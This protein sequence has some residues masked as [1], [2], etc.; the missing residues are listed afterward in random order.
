[1]KVLRLAA[2]LSFAALLG[3]CSWLLGGDEGE[4]KA[5]GPTL[6][7]LVDQLPQLQLATV[8]PVKPSREQVMAAY[9]RVYGMFPTVRENQAMA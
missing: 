9:N 1:M 6:G 2:L 5:K 3:G 7:R 4:I 8:D